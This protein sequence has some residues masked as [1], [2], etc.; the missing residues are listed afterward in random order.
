MGCDGQKL[1]KKHVA[2]DHYR[3][4]TAEYDVRCHGSR[5]DHHACDAEK[6]SHG[7]LALAKGM[8]EG[9]HGGFN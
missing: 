8:L 7:Q 1:A 9:T 2:K 6:A 3:P 5:C 4:D